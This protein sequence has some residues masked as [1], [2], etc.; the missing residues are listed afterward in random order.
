MSDV[1][2]VTEDKLKLLSKMHIG[3]NDCEFG[4]PA[5]D[6]KRP[7]GNSSVYSDIAAILH[8]E[9]ALDDE[10]SQEQTDDM[11]AIHQ[12]MQT[13]LQILAFNRSIEIGAYKAE[14]YSNE[15]HRAPEYDQHTNEAR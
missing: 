9:P 11:Y 15:W 2:Y 3:W 8:I 4:A 7:Y 13:V 10:F 1:F 14:K 5:V 12:S 6:C